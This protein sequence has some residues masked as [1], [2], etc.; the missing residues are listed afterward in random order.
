MI[1][2]THTKDLIQ[3]DIDEF[4]KY[5]P[6]A[7]C[8]IYSAGLNKRQNDRRVSFVGIQ[9]VYK[10]AFEFVK[11][12]LLIIDEAH[13]VNTEEG[14]QYARFIRD[15]KIANPNLCVLGM[16]AT[17]YRLDNGLLYEGKDRLFETLYYEI[18]L[19]R[20][21]DEG[22][23][24]PVISK[25]AVEKIDLDGVKTTAGDYNKKSLELAADKEALTRSAVE[26][27]RA[28]CRERV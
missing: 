23:L 12:D 10:R 4:K 8:G 3:Q 28:S 17:P 25:G 14:T 24:C 18:E 11:I 1:V 15:L 9:S 22:F 21:I 13:K 20:L 7:S 26:T 19:S 6:G 5:Y 27:G 2:A 16:S